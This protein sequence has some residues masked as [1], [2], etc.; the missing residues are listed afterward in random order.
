MKSVVIHAEGNVCVEERPISTL[1]TGNDALVEV[2]SSGLCG[3]DILH[4]SVKSVHHYPIMLRHGFSGYVGS[5]GTAV[6]G[7]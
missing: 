4:I 5:Y 2:A 6:T 1:Q 3:F 7:L